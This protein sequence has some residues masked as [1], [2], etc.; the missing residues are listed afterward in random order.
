[1]LGD[2]HL[3]HV[4]QSVDSKFPS[5]RRHGVDE[6]FFESFSFNALVGSLRVWVT[7]SSHHSSVRALW[8]ILTSSYA[9][10]MP[11]TL[12]GTKETRRVIRYLLTRIVPERP[13]KPGIRPSWA[14]SRV[15]KIRSSAS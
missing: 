3:R 15:S 9:L 1:H 2:C 10:W 6:L 8:I 14:P 13:L 11:A 4:D 12:P 7:K 5:D